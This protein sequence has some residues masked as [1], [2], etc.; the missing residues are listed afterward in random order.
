MSKAQLSA[1]TN[2]W[3]T[4][5]DIVERARRCMGGI[6]LDPCSEAKFNDIVQA[7]TY[8]SLLERDEDGL[9]LPWFGKILLNPPG[10]GH[11]KP[12]GKGKKKTLVR[13]FWEKMLSETFEQCVYVGF[14]NNQLGILADCDAH[15]T[16]FSIC[17]LRKRIGF[18]RHDNVPKKGVKAKGSPSHQN[19]IAGINI[20]HDAFVREFGDLGKI[21]RGPLAVD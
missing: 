10:K 5:D 2:R 6:T 4:A 9:A 20:P 12:A 15:P 14:S 18:N 8:Y 16:D 3:G 1:A 19:F 13:L 17:Y 21:Q 7:D 11:G